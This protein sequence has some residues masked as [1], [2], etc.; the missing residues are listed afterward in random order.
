MAGIED[1]IR[2]FRGT[3][4]VPIKEQI[5][6]PFRGK[7]FSTRPDDAIDFAS[8]Q[9]TY[10]G[11]VNYLDLT[12][13]EFE[14]A[15]NLSRNQRTGL[16]G[17]VIVDD[18]LLE[19][20]KTDVLKTIKARGKNLSKLALKGLSRLATLPAALVLNLFSTQSLNEGEEELLKKQLE[21]MAKEGN[22]DKPL[23][24]D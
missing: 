2:V 22:V 11:K 13:D 12:K 18:D 24:E 8:R 10:T 17:E 19:K 6:Y 21:E 4:N 1:I 5:N 3:E 14:K 16:S 9:G 23:Y 7:Y 15:K 20:Q